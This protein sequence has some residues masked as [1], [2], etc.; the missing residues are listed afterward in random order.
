M[1]WRA[2]NMSGT[3]GELGLLGVIAGI[4]GILA[5]SSIKHGDTNGAAAWS[6][7]LMAIVGAIKERWQNRTINDAQDALRSSIPGPDPTTDPNAKGNA[8]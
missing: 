6:T 4:A 7:L 5:F 8:K 2:P 3:G 1:N